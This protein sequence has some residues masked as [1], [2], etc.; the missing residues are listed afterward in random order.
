MSEHRIA[1]VL[2]AKLAGDVTWAYQLSRQILDFVVSP[3]PVAGL[4]VLFRAGFDPKASP[5]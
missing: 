3:L 4:Y 5:T 1:I 2:A